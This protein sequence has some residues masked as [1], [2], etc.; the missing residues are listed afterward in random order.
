MNMGYNEG[1][2]FGSG[3]SDLPYL[4]YYDSRYDADFVAAPHPPLRSAP[5]WSDSRSAYLDSLDWRRE[6]SSYASP[7]V[8]SDSTP[9]TVLSEPSA[10]SPRGSLAAS[11]Y[12]GYSLD[13]SSASDDIA[14]PALR[15]ADRLLSPRFPARPDAA[16]FRGGARLYP[17]PAPSGSVVLWYST[18]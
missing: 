5:S 6:R 14:E 12:H 4:P 16:F 9:R 13:G 18:R 17:A 1:S 8:L 15:S 11:V 3:Y 2:Q 7:P 10:H